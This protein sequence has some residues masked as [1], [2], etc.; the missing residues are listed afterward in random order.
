MSRS[1]APQDTLMEE[2][3]ETRRQGSGPRYTAEEMRRYQRIPENTGETRDPG[4][5]TAESKSS[6]ENDLKPAVRDRSTI[7]P[8]PSRFYA[9]MEGPLRTVRNHPA[10]QVSPEDLPAPRTSR[11]DDDHLGSHD[12]R[13]ANQR[14]GLT[15]DP[16]DK[17]TVPRRAPGHPLNINNNDNLRRVRPL[18]QPQQRRYFE[19]ES[20]YVSREV[21]RPTDRDL[22]PRSAWRDHD[23]GATP[24][25]QSRMVP[26]APE[27]R[28][29]AESNTRA[30]RGATGWD[31]PTDERRRSPQSQPGLYGYGERSGADVPVGREER[32]DWGDG[33]APN[34]DWPTRPRVGWEDTGP[35]RP[36]AKQN[37]DSHS[38]SAVSSGYGQRKAAESTPPRYGGWGQPLTF[39]TRQQER[40]EP[41]THFVGGRS[42]WEGVDEMSRV[43]RGTEPSGWDQPTTPP[44]RT[45]RTERDVQPTGWASPS[46]RPEPSA[47]VHS[48]GGWDPLES[49]P[50]TSQRGEEAG[51][52]VRSRHASDGDQVTGWGEAPSHTEVPEVPGTS[53]G[54]IRSSDNLATNGAGGM[55]GIEHA[56]EDPPGDSFGETPLRPGPQLVDMGIAKEY[57]EPHWFSKKDRWDVAEGE[58][59]GERNETIEEE[60]YQDQRLRGIDFENYGHIQVEV[61]AAHKDTPI[62]AAIKTFSDLE[63]DSVLQENIKLCK[64]ADPTPIQRHTIPIISEGFSLMACAQTGSGKTAAYMIPIVQR[65][66]EE[67]PAKVIKEEW[68]KVA[69]AAPRAVIIAPTRELACQ[70][71]DDA[72]RFCYRTFIRPGV[73]YGG[74]GNSR[75]QRNELE[76]GCDILIG[77]P[78][79]MFD[80]CDKRI[81]RLDKVLMLVIDEADRLFDRGFAPEVERLISEY[82]MPDAVERQ[83]SMF[84][85]TFPRDMRALARRW[86][87]EPM[88]ITVGKVGLVPKEINQKIIQVEGQRDKLDALVNLLS[89]EDTKVGLT[90]IF[91]DSRSMCDTLDNY[92]FTRDL[93]VTSYHS[94]RTQL[95]RED[96]LQ[97]FRS[98]K[99][100]IMVATGVAERGLDIPNV[101]HIINFDFPKTFEEYIHRI[102]RTGRVGR[103]GFATSFWNDRVSDECTEKV[104]K[105]LAEMGQEVPEFWERWKPQAVEGTDGNQTAVGMSTIDAEYLLE[106]PEEGAWKEAREALREGRYGER[107]F[108][109]SRL[110][111]TQNGGE[112][113]NID[114]NTVGN[115]GT[116][117]G[118]GWGNTSGGW[119]SSAG[120]AWG[121]GQQQEG[122]PHGGRGGWGQSADNGKPTVMHEEHAGNNTAVGRGGSGWGTGGTETAVGGGISGWGA[123]GND[124][125]AGGVSG[126]GA[127]GNGSG[128]VPGWGS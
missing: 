32:E 124:T 31:D 125:A 39:P 118:G 111:D 90:L 8:G 13:T 9:P 110:P 88:Y 65:L 86:L 83:T 120:G 91:V 29:L 37:T 43:G 77:T 53:P 59:Y 128:A 48:S 99:C 33:R 85:A 105:L 112:H 35:E 34:T 19:E 71:F 25:Q 84:S 100:P 18:E 55:I 38:A 20:P 89:S 11:Y 98:N 23:A 24:D 56:S 117:G 62:P 114:S 57:T 66:L 14:A 108:T 122:E 74:M 123:R 101:I 63:M 103:E 42:Q 68:Q 22:P 106:E 113:E 121:A 119:G 67:G 93:P 52:Q 61:R 1:G 17:S 6:T 10:Q 7:Q 49:T 30:V 54:D 96:A 21:S 45:A 4:E 26:I 44:T 92:L 79:R 50:A 97:A 15:A 64:F 94:E 102:G 115:A 95:E 69:T 126:W 127:G 58:R 109:S 5:M 78:G 36:L 40:V 27:R 3:I 104:A 107:D 82:G 12:S 70:I 51:R 73:I 47:A 76:R 60:L 41:E 46:S 16:R 87:S 80:F 75:T 81:I 28:G 72:R 2:S 116:G